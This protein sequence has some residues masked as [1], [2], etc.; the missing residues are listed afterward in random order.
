M[1]NN[2]VSAYPWYA[3]KNSITSV[4][5]EEGVTSLGNNAFQ[6]HYPM[7][8]SVTFPSTLT[9]IGNYAFNYCTQLTTIAFPEGLTTIGEYAF[10]N[11][12]RLTSIT[13]ENGLTTI[14]K[15]AFQY[16]TG[17]T[18]LVFPESLTSLGDNTFSYCSGL[19]EITMQSDI[20]VY[21]TTFNKTNLQTL[22]LSNAVTTVYNSILSLS[23][24][25]TF[26]VDDTD[27]K[28][29]YSM[30]GVL[31]SYDDTAD[32]HTLIRFPA[33]KNEQEF[34]ILDG[35]V[36]IANNAISYNPYLY[37]VNI[38][39]S[40]VTIGTDVFKNC[41]QLS[42]LRWGANVTSEDI[43]GCSNSP[44]TTVILPKDFVVLPKPY[45]VTHYSVLNETN[46]G[47][48]DIDGVLYFYDA[49]KDLLTISYYPR[50]RMDATYTIAEETDIIGE[51]AF[52]GTNKYLTTVIFPDSVTK[53]DS[54][55]FY[56]CNSL[57]NVQLNEGLLTIGSSAFKSCTA[58]AEIQIPKT[59]TSLDYGAFQGCSALEQISIP[60]SVTKIGL[61]AFYLCSKL[62]KAYFY[63]DA[64]SCTTYSFSDTHSTFTIY[65]IEGKSGWTTPKW[66]GYKTATFVPEGYSLTLTDDATYVLT[67]DAVT[68]IAASTTV[69]AFTEQ[70]SNAN[71]TVTTATGTSLSDTALV[72]T[73]CVIRLTVD[74]SVVDTLTIIVTGDMDGDGLSNATDL[75]MLHKYYSGY[76]VT[77]DYPA[78]ADLNGDGNMTRAD[79]MVL[80]RQLAGWKDATTPPEEDTIG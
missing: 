65:Y 36:A 51:Y 48:Q 71:I 69:S 9:T 3:Y 80:A 58:L 41:E 22:H 42:T 52:F 53:I 62:Q 44:V 28:G 19:T 76:P 32:A 59:V 17:L 34:T 78:A 40:V 46:E 64:P 25:T 35:T 6:T 72:G 10:Y 1:E 2:S 15:Y 45:A 49:S 26:D 67:D 75:T 20:S 77:I 79:A 18:S 33:A 50:G 16:C 73:G 66:N 31:Y 70:F 29:L 68:G 7:I 54:S 43:A 24:L 38:A 27:D 74:G 37:R 30:D 57:T 14:G 61:Y 21:T 23:T 12:T 60:S 11:C 63:G 56:G 13:F 5:I 47:Y 8:A 55:A 4:V 39:D